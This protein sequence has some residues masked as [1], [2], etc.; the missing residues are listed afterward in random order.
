MSDPGYVAIGRAARVIGVPGKTVRR[1]VAAGTL[2]VV[3]GQ[4]DGDTITNN[5]RCEGAGVVFVDENASGA[6]GDVRE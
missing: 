5:V 6:L 4:E 3:A 2:P 1:W